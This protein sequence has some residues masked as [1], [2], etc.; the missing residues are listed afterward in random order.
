MN[1]TETLM[2]G[3]KMTPQ[4]K[5]AILYQEHHKNIAKLLDEFV[6]QPVVWLEDWGAAEYQE[7]MLLKKDGHYLLR[8]EKWWKHSDPESYYDISLIPESV[9]ALNLDKK[10]GKLHIYTITGG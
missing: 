8:I 1:E 5:I 7:A 2:F 4:E 3:L 9:V 6:K 10:D